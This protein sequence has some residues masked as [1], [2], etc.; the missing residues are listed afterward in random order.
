MDFFGLSDEIADAPSEEDVQCPAYEIWP[1][2]RKALNLFLALENQWEIVISPDGEMIRT[3]LRLP[4]IESMLRRTNGIPAREWNTL[5]E[6]M[7]WMERPALSEMTKARMARQE[8]REAEAEQSRN[9]Q[10]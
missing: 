1:E 4:S 5:F 9:N 8:K 3:G 2:N 6:K 7:L 10:R